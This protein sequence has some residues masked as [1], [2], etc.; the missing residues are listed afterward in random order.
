M[1]KDVDIPAIHATHDDTLGTDE[2]EMEQ[3]SKLV[4][5][6]GMGDERRKL[7]NQDTGAV[8]DGGPLEDFRDFEHREIVTQLRANITAREREYGEL[9]QA[10]TA[11]TTKLERPFT[12]PPGMLVSSR[13]R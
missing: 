7:L 1:S 4:D 13:R 11:T 8:V 6:T 5:I 12:T 10:H 3:P 9:V 2:L